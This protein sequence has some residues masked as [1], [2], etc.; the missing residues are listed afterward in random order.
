MIAPLL[1]GII[2]VCRGCTAAVAREKHSR[3]LIVVNMTDNFSGPLGG[4]LSQ[5]CLRA[6]ERMH[7]F[8]GGGMRERQQV[9][10]S[11]VDFSRVHVRSGGSFE[12]SSAAQLRTR[13]S[14]VSCRTGES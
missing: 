7:A 13:Q 8:G 5:Q 9:E 4:R 11:V 1:S 2:S 10:R 14:C 6:A 12:A 3:S